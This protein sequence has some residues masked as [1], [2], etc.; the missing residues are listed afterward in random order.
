MSDSIASH[1][2]VLSDILDILND[3]IL[4]PSPMDTLD[5]L[6]DIAGIDADLLHHKKTKEICPGLARV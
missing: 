5:G 1:P 3:V 2:S 6:P 4:S